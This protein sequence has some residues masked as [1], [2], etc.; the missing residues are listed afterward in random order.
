M[1]SSGKNGLNIRLNACPKWDRTR[2]PGEYDGTST[3]YVHSAWDEEILR[4]N[5]GCTMTT[6][7]YSSE[8][9]TYHPNYK[10]QKSIKIIKKKK[11]KRYLYNTSWL[12][13][14]SLMTM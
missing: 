7:I 6:L 10:S 5:V 12:F 3:F 14:F 4:E 2:F 9:S 8:V 1:T 13:E 11:I